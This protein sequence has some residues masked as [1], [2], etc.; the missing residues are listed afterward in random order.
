MR[1]I[2]RRGCIVTLD[3]VEPSVQPARGEDELRARVGAVELPE[4][5]RCRDVAAR[6]K[7]GER[8]GVKAALQPDPCGMRRVMDRRRAEQR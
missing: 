7:R 4:T 6:V 2:H 1:G 8:I 3:A 5:G